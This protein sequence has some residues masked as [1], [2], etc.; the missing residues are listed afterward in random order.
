MALK[1]HLIPYAFGDKNE[2][3]RAVPHHAETIDF[4]A[5][6]NKMLDK[7]TLV[8]STDI[9]AV[10]S[11]FHEVV[12]SE[13]KK[14]NKIITPLFTAGIRLEGTFANQ[15][16]PINRNKHKV[17]ISMQANRNLEKEIRHLRL[18]R[19]KQETRTAN[20]IGMSNPFHEDFNT[21]MPGD[22][23]QVHGHYFYLNKEDPNQGI[24][25]KSKD[26]LYPIERI[27]Q[28]RP[29]VIHMQL[30]QTME[31]GAYSIEFL[32]CSRKG[33]PQKVVRSEFSLYVPAPL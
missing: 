11:L 4:E 13:L 9:R 23:I 10:F 24:W 30:P 32:G 2:R 18:Q 26:H 29:S 27:A 3:Y 22:M 20:I 25:L 31:P 12:Q 8:T 6:I 7:G 5:L 15:Q 21:A 17:H 16:E 1:Y 14:G 33:I 19:S 28:I